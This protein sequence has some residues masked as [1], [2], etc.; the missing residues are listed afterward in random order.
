MLPDTRSFRKASP[1]IEG[2][3]SSNP[4]ASEI[5]FSWNDYY[6][7]NV[8]TDWNGEKSNQTAR[9]YRIQVDNDSSFASPVDT[10]TVDQTTYTE[11]DKLYADGTYFW[12]VQALDDENQGLT[13]SAP[14]T[15][16]KTS[17]PVTP[18]SPVGGAHVSGSTPFRWDAAPFAASYT[19][20]V[21]KNNDVA[22]SSTNRVVSASVKTTAY[23]PTTPLPAD[24][25]NYLWRVRRADASGNPGPWSDAESFFS[26]GAAPTLVQPNAGVWVGNRSSL[27]EW[28]EV[29]GAAS[30]QL[31]FGGAS[32]SK[33]STAA[34]AYAPTATLR[35]GAYTWRVI[36]LDSGGHS[37]GTSETRD[38]RV[39]GTPPQVTSVTPTTLK[40]KSVIK[41]T[42]S[43]RVT[44]V[45]GKSMKLYKVKGKRKTRIDAVVSTAKKGKV[46]TLDP[47]HLLKPGNYLVV[48]VAPKIKDQAGN[49]LVP[50]SVTPALKAALRRQ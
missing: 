11:Y 41:A 35:D 34:T 47:K 43:E 46:A 6:E 16:T 8:A 37:L 45:S 24:A 9:T 26:T 10:K 15:F 27:F 28:S 14:Q 25:T 3:T 5:T 1:A 49:T 18:D 38:F 4:N 31:V 17:P 20:E 2:L 32:T 40:P 29:P 13:W 39:D 19:I 44:G 23:A 12:R 30:Y 36:A 50:S 33:F 22:F 7:T 21:Y 48:F 42:F